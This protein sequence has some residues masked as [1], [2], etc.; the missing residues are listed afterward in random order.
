MICLLRHCWLVENK[1]LSDSFFNAETFEITPSAV[2]VTHIKNSLG[3]S[4]YALHELF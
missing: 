4:E 1:Q 3:F 2:I